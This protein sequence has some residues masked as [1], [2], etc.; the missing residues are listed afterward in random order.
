MIGKRRTTCMQARHALLKPDQRLGKPRP[1]DV[2]QRAERPIAET[3][4]RIDLREAS[5][6]VDRLPVVLGEPGCHF[7]RPQQARVRTGRCER[8]TPVVGEHLRHQG[9]RVR[10][11]DVEC[12]EE[13]VGAASAKSG[14]T[15][16]SEAQ[17]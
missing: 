16:V 15:S 9:L 13:Y 1:E 11:G 8:V 3:T 4:T 14:N 6:R 7:K 17:S 2:L 12:L 5:E 10:D